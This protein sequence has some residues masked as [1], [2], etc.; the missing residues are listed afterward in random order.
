MLGLDDEGGITIWHFP[1]LT[2]AHYSSP[3][4]VSLAFASHSHSESHTTP[5]KGKSKRIPALP[6][7]CV[8]DMF[9]NTA[10]DKEPHDPSM[11]RIEQVEWWS[12]DDLILVRATG[13]LVIASL[14]SF[15]N[16]LAEGLNYAKGQV[17]QQKLTFVVNNKDRFNSRKRR[18]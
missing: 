6:L 18:G 2:H 5:V 14:Q 10:F 3:Q 11:T 16:R 1:S 8:A 15:R 9:K 4:V 17:N 13:E 7:L 12:E